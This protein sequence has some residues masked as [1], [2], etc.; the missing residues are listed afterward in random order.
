MG[1]R[2]EHSLSRCCRGI[3]HLFQ[4]S[5]ALVRIIAMEAPPFLVEITEEYIVRAAAG[6]ARM[7]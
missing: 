2:A 4:I 5:Q 3:R 7:K 6:H 1:G